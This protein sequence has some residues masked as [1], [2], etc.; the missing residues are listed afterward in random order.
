MYLTG[1]NLGQV[2]NF[3]S[4]CLHDGNVLRCVTKTAKLKVENSVQKNF[5]VISC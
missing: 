2:F 4:V 1:R 5:K 3:R